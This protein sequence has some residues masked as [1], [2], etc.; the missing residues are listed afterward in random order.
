M[1][2]D[3]FIAFP[4]RKLFLR[5]AAP[6]VITA[7]FGALYSVIDG[8]FVGRFLGEDALAAVNLIMPIIMIVEAISNMIA[9]GAAVNISI[10]LGK[11][12]REE[13]CRV[14]SF[15]VKFIL[16][17]SCIISLPGFFFAHS[18]VTLLAPG[19]SELAIQLGVQYLQVFA[20]F[21]PLI[22]VYFAMDNFL[23]VCGKPRLSM[24][25][26]IASQVINVGLNFVF[27]VLLHQGMRAAAAASCISIVLG[28]AVTL[29]LF[30]GRRMDVYY[31]RG[32]LP[33]SRFLR[34]ISNGSS[35]FFTSIATSVMSVIMNLF[36]LRYGGSTAVAAFSIVMYVDG[37]IGMISFEISDSMQPAISY[38]YGAKAMDRMWKIFRIVVIVTL[39][40]SVLAFL[41]MYLAGPA[42][43]RLFIKPGD[44]ELLAM[45]V[46]AVKIFAFSY[47]AG[48]VDTCFSSFFTALDR[49]GRSLL[50]AVFGTMVFPIAALF[51]LTAQWGL[52][53]VWLMAP[54]SAFASAILTLFLAGTLIK[55]LERE[56][57]H[58]FK[59]F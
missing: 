3:L 8:I 15:S 40:L 25:I 41:L 14:F 6:A 39:I 47:L 7:V 45:S 59:I 37:I 54:V 38:C 27:I 23:R 44:T 48:W 33:G 26:N 5:C 13:A 53:G 28:S 21:G 12:E 16:F 43:A 29:F 50:V 19:A 9:T 58:H 10:L 1:N 11:G 51:L 36:L 2:S 35:E 52:A 24:F 56:S 42:F 46:I 17:F 22:P 4:V 55:D 30:K 57:H 18:F 34:I 20:M 32:N 31:I 49:P